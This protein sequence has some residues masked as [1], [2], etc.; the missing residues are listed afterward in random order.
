M[1]RR[2]LKKK[3]STK[4]SKIEKF[5]QEKT[6]TKLEKEQEA[7]KVIKTVDESQAKKSE[8]KTGKN[9]DKADRKSTDI[10]EHDVDS[11]S[12]K[13]PIY[14]SIPDISLSPEQHQIDESLDADTLESNIVE[15][16]GVD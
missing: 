10:K 3:K 7:T 14:Q 1:F 2:S 13:E 11:N 5:Q 12:N 6:E 16:P 15:L 9:Q 4:D 8:T